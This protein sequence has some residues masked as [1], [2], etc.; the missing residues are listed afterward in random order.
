MTSEHSSV[1]ESLVDQRWALPVD[2]LN[3]PAESLADGCRIRCGLTV[4]H[5]FAIL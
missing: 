2:G 3:Q 5:Q 4:I 1:Q